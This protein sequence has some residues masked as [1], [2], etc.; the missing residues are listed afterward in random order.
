MTFVE[1]SHFSKIRERYLD[2]DQYRLLQASLMRSPEEGA[3]IVGSGG[4]RKL[5]WNA[6]RTGKQGGMRVIYCWQP[7]RSR[8][9]LMT[10]YR[11]SEVADLTKAEIRILR[12]LLLEIETGSQEK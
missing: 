1:T 11:K 7:D 3:V 9:F 2:D 8:M 10:I 4:I 12:S 6:E 5:R